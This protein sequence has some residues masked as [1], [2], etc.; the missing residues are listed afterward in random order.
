MRSSKL[1]LAS[2]K[3]GIGLAIVRV[4]FAGAAP[5]HE[6]NWISSLRMLTQTSIFA[7]SA[8]VRLNVGRNMETIALKHLIAKQLT[9]IQT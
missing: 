6:L 4:S 7:C 8:E 1:N 3:G 5:V 2:M 9:Y